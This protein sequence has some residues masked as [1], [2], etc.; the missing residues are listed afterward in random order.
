MKDVYH[1]PVLKPQQQLISTVTMFLEADQISDS[2]DEDILH[3]L[4]QFQQRIVSLNGL[5][6]FCLFPL[7]V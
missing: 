1:C 2:L 3:I 5:V 6:S 4:K 7:F